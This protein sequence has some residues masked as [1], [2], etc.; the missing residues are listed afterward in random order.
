M[1][2]YFSLS[3]KRPDN[4]LASNDIHKARAVVESLEEWAK[5]W[6]IAKLFGGPK[7]VFNECKHIEN[8]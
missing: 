5:V 6:T 8:E 2:N 3:L 7:H 4:R 1:N